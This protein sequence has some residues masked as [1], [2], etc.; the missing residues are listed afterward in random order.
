MS[1][2][3]SAGKNIA[4][5]VPSHQYDATVSF[6][7]D[8]LG[9]EQI[10]GPSGN[11]TGFKF[12]D[13]NLWIDN[14]AGMSQAEIWLEIVTNDTAE[15]ARVLEKAGIARCDEIEE[16]GDKFDGFWISS[17]SSIILLLDADTGSWD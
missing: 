14:V 2:R 13:K 12:G 9:F 5:K 1:A 11:A 16:L 6:Y 8:L 10:S 7:R 17:P 4:M 3:F 15:A